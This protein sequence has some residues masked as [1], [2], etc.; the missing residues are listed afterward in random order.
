MGAR[1]ATAASEA[2]DVV[3]IEDSIKNLASAIDISQA[4][5]RKATQS[6]GAGMAL[7]IVAMAAAA[8]GFLTATQS[9]LIQEIIDASAILWAL[10]PLALR[11][12]KEHQ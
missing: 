11:L 10:T 5:F 1:G 12:K 4:A 3:I 2:A 9:A 6:A 7:A 8:F